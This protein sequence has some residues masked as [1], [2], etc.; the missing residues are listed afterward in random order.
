MELRH[1]PWPLLYDVMD[2]R[3]YARTKAII[4]EID[5]SEKKSA[6]DYPDGPMTDA[7]L[8]NEARI[9]RAKMEERSKSRKKK[10]SK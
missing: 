4:E 3:A 8:D 1:G 6:D 9:M 5:K 10:V 7:V 2:V